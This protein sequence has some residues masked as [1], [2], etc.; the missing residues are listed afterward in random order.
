M[1]P[2]QVL[3]QL[4][5]LA[6]SGGFSPQAAETVRSIDLSQLNNLRITQMLASRLQKNDV[7]SVEMLVN[8]AGDSV[9][10]YQPQLID[11]DNNS[12][13]ELELAICPQFSF[14]VTME[15]FLSRKSI[16]APG[17]RL[18]INLTELIR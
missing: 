12:V 16:N 10:Y 15:I 8:R 4:L 9:L 7:S 6:N 14:F 17:V 2:S 3:S 1:T 13:Q 11:D 5:L 18:L